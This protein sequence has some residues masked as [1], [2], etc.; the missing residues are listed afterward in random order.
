MARAH[1]SG[2]RNPRWTRDELI[3]ALD[4]YLRT[5]PHPPDK[6]SREIAELSATLLDGHGPPRREAIRRNRL[7]KGR[8]LR[9]SP[10]KAP[11]RE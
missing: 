11:R 3:L 1:S 4:L 6:T 2:E 5:R 10:S 8:E 7:R 9:S